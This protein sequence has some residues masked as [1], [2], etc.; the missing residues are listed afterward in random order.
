MVSRQD[1]ISVTL[2]YHPLTLASG[3][4][5]EKTEDQVTPAR[6]QAA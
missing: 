1:F 2:V 6:A 5:F 3:L 4:L